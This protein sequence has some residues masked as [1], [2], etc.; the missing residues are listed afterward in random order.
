MH[1][2][3][4]VHIAKTCISLGIQLRL[5]RINFFISYSHYKVSHQIFLPRYVA[6]INS[7]IKSIMTLPFL[8]KILTILNRQTNTIISEPLCMKTP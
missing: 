1:L 5:M 6:K 2:W 7:K 8:V 4:P 3:Q